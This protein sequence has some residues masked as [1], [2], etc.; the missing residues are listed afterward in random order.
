MSKENTKDILT[1][2]KLMKSKEALAEIGF[3]FGEKLMTADELAKLKEQD[4][5]N[6]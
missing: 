3:N 6:K 4:E 1:E 5:E 2:D